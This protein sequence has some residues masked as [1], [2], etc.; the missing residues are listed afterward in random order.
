MTAHLLERLRTLRPTLLLLLVYVLVSQLSQTLL[1]TIVT[2]LVSLADKTGA[3]FGNA[4]NEIAGQYFLLSLSLAAL[5]VAITVHQADRALY[6][7]QP[8]WNDHN[9]P[10]WQLDRVRKEELLRGVSNGGLAAL[11]YLVFFSISGQISYLGV[12]IS[13]AIGTPI[14]PL[15]FMDLAGLVV[16]LVCEEFLF[17][18][19]V[20]R[21]L[22]ALM[23][24]P[25]AI[26]LTGA[27]QV[28]VRHWQFQL[29]PF[30]Y[31]NLFLLNV[32]LGY[33]YLRSRKFQRGLGFL[34][35]LVV[36][37]HSLSGLPLWGNESPSFFLFKAAARA[38]AFLTGGAGGPFAGAGMLGILLLFVVASYLSWKREDEAKRQPPEPSRLY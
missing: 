19:K 10:A 1:Y 28:L 38:P 7:A 21:N 2:Y 3:E 36:L 16:F 25:L 32:A 13:S 17:R 5:L 4:V 29:S 9:R 33:F 12:Y 20:L 35:A 31:L 23:P 15:I 6:R 22:L 37:M 24:A 27:L 34:L 8:F 11:V 18:H 30:D 26:A 14:F